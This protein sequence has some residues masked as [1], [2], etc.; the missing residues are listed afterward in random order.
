MLFVHYAHA[1]P[2]RAFA[3]LVLCACMFL[4]VPQSKC[5]CNTAIDPCTTQR[6]NKLHMKP[7][8]K[9]ISAMNLSVGCRMCL[10]CCAVGDCSEARAVG[11]R[12]LCVVSAKTCRYA[13][14]AKQHCCFAASALKGVLAAHLHNRNAQPARALAVRWSGPWTDNPG[15]LML[16]L[17]R[18]KHAAKHGNRQAVNFS[19]AQIA[20]IG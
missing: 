3:L 12:K 2:A 8:C 7:S 18:L 4:Y 20:C 11:L 16:L 1:R 14:P 5:P 10:L 13:V 15:A 6:H 17:T 9:G 19:L